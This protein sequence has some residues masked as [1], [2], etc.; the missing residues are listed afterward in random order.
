MTK[1]KGWF[2]NYQYPR[3]LSDLNGDGSLDLI[4]FG[5]NDISASQSIGGTYN[6]PFTVI[7]SNKTVSND[8]DTQNI[9]GR[10]AAYKFYIPYPTDI[11]V[12][13]CFPETNFQETISIYDINGNNLGFLYTG[14]F[15]TNCFLEINMLPAGY[16]YVVIDGNN[17]AVGDFK[18]QVTGV[19][20]PMRLGHFD[21]TKID[22]IEQK[23]DFNIYPNP[24]NGTFEIM[25]SENFVSG[26]I[27]I[28]DIFG[29]T[30][31]TD[32]I[33]N[34]E[35]KIINDLESGIYFVKITDLNGLSNMKKVI[36]EK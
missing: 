20:Y 11:S 32:R 24:N 16:Y 30:L 1:S 26:H 17:G 9:D 28:I 27:E 12:T 7:S 21:E 2:N 4:G 29:K 13:T 36:I 10:D 33:L 19:S 35:T 8:W 14:K 31:S 6:I 25:V 18:L 5:Y 3:S 23:N 15:S 22:S 34:K